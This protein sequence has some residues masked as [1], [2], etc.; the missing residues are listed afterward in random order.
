[1]VRVLFFSHLLQVGT[2]RRPG[3]FVNQSGE[4]S[5]QNL[6][7]VPSAPKRRRIRHA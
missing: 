3:R 6:P 2:V 7:A 4:V 1:M 5:M